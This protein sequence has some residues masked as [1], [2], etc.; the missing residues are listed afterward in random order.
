MAII[1]P[2]SCPTTVTPGENDLF[3]A[4]F[5]NL[6]DDFYI[7]YEP[8]SESQRPDFLLLSPTFGILV[9]EVKDW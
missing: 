5:C 9:L 2:D 6:P 4:L 7:W 1:Y 3:Q 8:Y